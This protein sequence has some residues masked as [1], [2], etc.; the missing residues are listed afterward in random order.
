[1]AEDTPEGLSRRLAGVA[2]LGVRVEGPA[3]AVAEAL[4]ALPGVLRVEP[5]A[6]DEHAGRAF[7]VFAADVDPVQRALGAAVVARGWTLLEV[8]VSTPS[9]EDLFVRLVG[10]G[11]GTEDAAR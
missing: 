3:A 7:A 1:V 2:R 4:G 6:P 8:S 10:P 5:A 11:A 9:L